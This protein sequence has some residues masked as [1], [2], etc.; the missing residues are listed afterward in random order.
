MVTSS[1]FSASSSRWLPGLSRWSGSAYSNNSRIEFVEGHFCVGA[2]TD[3]EI[4]AE[5]ARLLG[6]LGGNPAV[7]GLAAWWKA[8]N[9][10]GTTL[11]DLIGS[12]H[13]TITN[14]LLLDL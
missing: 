1:A 8:D 2:L 9:V 3:D 6:G 11:P 4:R 5:H 7:S 10:T 14:G 12:N 13:G